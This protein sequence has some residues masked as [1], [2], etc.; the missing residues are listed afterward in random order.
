[1]N[2]TPTPPLFCVRK[3]IASLSERGGGRARKV[4]IPALNAKM[5][6]L[7]H[8]RCVRVGGLYSIHVATFACDLK[9][10]FDAACAVAVRFGA[11]CRQRFLGEMG[12]CLR[13][14]FDASSAFAPGKTVNVLEN[15][16][17]LFKG[18]FKKSPIKMQL[19]KQ[20]CLALRRLSFS[21]L[22]SR[23]QWLSGNTE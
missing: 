19:W 14:A 22:W 8:G 21:S 5:V 11:A 4:I 3:R 16:T 1:M 9:G 18:V 6:R 13:G 23:G 10:V 15:E 20:G 17:I 2:T 7:R 12:P